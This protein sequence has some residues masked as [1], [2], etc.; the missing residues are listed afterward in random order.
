MH[1]YHFSVVNQRRAERFQR[2][3]ELVMTIFETRPLMSNPSSS[4]S[5]P[6]SSH[7]SAN[8]DSLFSHLINSIQ[9]NFIFKAFRQLSDWRHIC[10]IS[11]R[12]DRGQLC[13]SFS[14][15]HI[16]ASI[17]QSSRNALIKEVLLM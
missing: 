13:Q 10:R 1:S 12:R 14:T 5:S 7:L 8:N 6:R 16:Q 15:W 11:E 3:Q 4:R 17:R 2:L 9:A